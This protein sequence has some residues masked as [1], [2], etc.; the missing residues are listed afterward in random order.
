MD[1]HSSYLI[2]RFGETVEDVHA[3]EGKITTPTRF[4][5]TETPGFTILTLSNTGRISKLRQHLYILKHLICTVTI[6]TIHT[7]TTKRILLQWQVTLEPV[8]Q[9]KSLTILRIYHQLA[10]QNTHHQGCKK[11]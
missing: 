5:T 3:S 2:W 11:H 8:Y 4:L 9:E 1:H 6:T 7:V 10:H